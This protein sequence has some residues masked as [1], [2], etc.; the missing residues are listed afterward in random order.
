MKKL[1]L[2]DRRKQ[3]RKKEKNGERLPCNSANVFK[4][5]FKE[6]KWEDAQ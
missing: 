1:K 6:E 3:R 5:L 4:A 2:G